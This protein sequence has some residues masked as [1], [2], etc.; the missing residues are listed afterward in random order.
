MCRGVVGMDRMLVRGMVPHVLRV[1]AVMAGISD[2]R[3]VAGVLVGQGCRCVV[4]QTGRVEGMGYGWGER[5]SQD[6]ETRNPGGNTTQISTQSHGRI[7]SSVHYAVP[8]RGLQKID[9]F[10]WIDPNFAR[11]RSGNYPQCRR[12]GSC[13]DLATVLSNSPGGARRCRRAVRS[14]ASRR[15]ACHPARCAAARCR[16]ADRES[17]R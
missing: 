9:Q 11:R 4:R 13:S 7:L 14:S 10:A 6:R 1:S 15:P 17:G 16:T 2:L 5:R 12:D 8:G 3:G